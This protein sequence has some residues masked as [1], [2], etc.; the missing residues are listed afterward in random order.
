MIPQPGD[1]VLYDVNPHSGWTS[2]LV[3]MGELWAGIGRGRV[4][5]SHVAIYDGDGFQFEAKYPTVGRFRIDVR[6]R[7]IIKAIPRITKEQRILMLAT[8]RAHIGD[9]Y[10]LAGLFS[11]GFFGPNHQEVCSQLVDT[12]AIAAGIRIPREG[13]RLLTPN[14][15]ADY[16]G[17]GL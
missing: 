4:M 7:P 8:A 1:L 13:Q 12:C 6:R 15:I 9:R 14:A 3:A 11:L 17:V 5:F 16:L 10:N 2:K